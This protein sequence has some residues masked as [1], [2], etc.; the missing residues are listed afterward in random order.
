MPPKP[1]TRHKKANTTIASRNRSYISKKYADY[2]YAGAGNDLSSS[3]KGSSADDTLSPSLSSNALSK[4]SSSPSSLSPYHEKLLNYI[5]SNVIGDNETFLSPFG[6]RKITYADYIASGRS[7]AFIEDFI[8]K[9][10]LPVYANTHTTTSFTGLQA[11]LFRYEAR[12]M[13]LKAVNGAK[14]HKVIFSGSGA[15]GA[16]NQLVHMMTP[17]SIKVVFVGPYEHHSNILPWRECGAKIVFVDEDADKGG[18]DLLDLEDKLKKHCGSTGGSASTRTKLVGAFSAASNV[19]GILTDTNAVTALLHKYNVFS[20]WDYACAAPYIPIDMRPVVE[21]PHHNLVRKDAIV[22]SPHKFIGGVQ[23]PGVLVVSKYMI[24]NNVPSNPGGGTVFFVTQQDHRYL[25]KP[26]ER[27]EGGTPEIVGAVRAALSMQLKN[28][29]GCTLIG[30]REDTFLKRALQKWG[31]NE[32]LII[33]GN[34]NA[35]RLAVVSFLISHG[36]KFL[37]SNFVSTILNDLF[38]IQTRSGCQCA[39]PYSLSLLGLDHET[40]KSF[41]SCLLEHDDY[42]FLRPGYTRLNF[43]YFLDETQFNYIVDAVDFIATHGWKLLPHYTFYPDTSEWIHYDQKKNINRRWLHNISYEDGTFSYRQQVNTKVS[44]KMYARYLKEA[45]TIVEDAVDRF[46]SGYKLADQT[47]LLPEHAEALRWFIYPSEALDELAS[48]RTSADFASGSPFKPVRYFENRAKEVE[49]EVAVVRANANTTEQTTIQIAQKQLWP[50]PNGEK[51]LL[52][53]KPE[54]E[55]EKRQLF[56][57]IPSKTLL[58]P[59]VKAVKEFGMIKQGDRLLLGLSGGKDS[60]SLLHVLHE[61]RKKSP[62]KFEIGACTVDPQTD[63][64]DPAPLKKYL[65]ALNVPYYFESQNVIELAKEKCATSI[66]SWCSRMKRGILY[67]VARQHGYNVL[68][69]GQHTDDFTESFLM[70]IFHNGYLRTMKASYDIDAGDIRVIRP[71]VYVREKILK[72]FARE[73]H[74]PVINENCPACFEMP[75]ERAR[76]KT[77]LST[78]EHL[79]PNIHSTIMRA[80]RPIMEEDLVVKAEHTRKRK[81]HKKYSTAFQ[82]I[83]GN[84]K[85]IPALVE[86]KEST[87]EPKVNGSGPETAEV[88]PVKELN[89]AQENDK[90]AVEQAVEDPSVS[91]EAE[92]CKHSWFSSLLPTVYVG[93][94]VG[95]GLSVSRFMTKQ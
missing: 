42:E 43:N 36:G 30:Q 29:V 60:L 53:P 88:E 59:T 19:T 83:K 86:N 18:V 74:L 61:L 52:D 13:I 33:L 56:P 40:A 64:Y 89:S 80:L 11:T 93:L 85:N 47:H 35:P 57:K 54:I 37:H 10:I 15:T 55:F 50:T 82:H 24:D 8:R 7:L 73:N 77:L 70:S 84:K 58:R 76:I 65:K 39:G 41:E 63:S 75:K 20:V 23:T 49:D 68:V 2:L 25:K 9:E 66:C 87:P 46:T 79:F 90:G 31:H 22:F 14:E 38:G 4:T 17:E 69:L 67:N 21:G 51:M 32:N 95:I 45:K 94:G 34:R 1:D 44:D 6:H 5:R 81:E 16:L 27:E 48:G 91:I 78:Q 72:K 26:Y 28:A 71:L 92:K 3:A 62:V 12:E